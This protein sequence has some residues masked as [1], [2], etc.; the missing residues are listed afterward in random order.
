MI[1]REKAKK[2]LKRQR[3]RQFDE[4]EPVQRNMTIHMVF[5]LHD[6]R[7]E[8]VKKNVRSSSCNAKVV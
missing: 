4:Q 3:H 7:R 8:S 6:T 2:K 5:S 1:E